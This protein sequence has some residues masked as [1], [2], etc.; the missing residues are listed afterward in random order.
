M[1]L[2]FKMIYLAFLLYLTVTVQRETGK[3]GERERGWM[4]C[5]NES[6]PESIPGRC[7]DIM[8]HDLLVTEMK[9]SLHP[10]AH[11][12]SHQWVTCSLVRQTFR[13]GIHFLFSSQENMTQSSKTIT[14]TSSAQLI[15]CRLDSHFS[16]FRR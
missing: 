8:W 13:L 7:G 3:T 2:F 5:S 10:A 12:L 15:I 16:E 6:R 9:A 11:F 4:T 1:L 14:K